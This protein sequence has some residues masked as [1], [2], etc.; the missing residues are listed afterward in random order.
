[1]ATSSGSE[2]AAIAVTECPA[3]AIQLLRYRDT[4]VGAEIAA[5]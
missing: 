5:L 2:M 3:K 4:Q 1:L